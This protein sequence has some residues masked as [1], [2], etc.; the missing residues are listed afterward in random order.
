MYA[1]GMF[2]IGSRS[3]VVAGVHLIILHHPVEWVT[4]RV[5]ENHVLDQRRLGGAADVDQQVEHVVLVGRSLA[6]AA[7][8]QQL[9][10]VLPR[11]V[12][13]DPHQLRDDADPGAGRVGVERARQLPELDR[14]LPR[15]DGRRRSRVAAEAGRQAARLHELRDR[16]GAGA[17]HDVARR[18]GDACRRRRR[19]RGVL[20][21]RRPA[22]DVERVAAAGVMERVG[23]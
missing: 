15:V 20:L 6:E 18:V 11:P 7:G 19:R 17:V 9:V 8:P 16:R 5:L 23:F 10:D 21:V 4:N 1:T 2:H 14:R 12:D 22:V 3:R 13:G